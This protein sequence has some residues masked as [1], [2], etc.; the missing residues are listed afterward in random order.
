MGLPRLA[1]KRQCIFHF[2][3]WNILSLSLQP[4]CKQSVL[5][6]SSS[7]QTSWIRPELHEEREG[8]SISPQLLQSPPD[9]ICQRNPKLDLPSRPPEFLTS[10]T[11]QGSKRIAGFCSFV[12]L[13]LRAFI[14]YLGIYLG[15]E[16]YRILTSWPGIQP[17][18][19]NTLQQW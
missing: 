1:H 18:P 11:M 7:R 19:G 10:E 8:Y 3:W 2:I 14:F 4:L 6:G 13:L 5:W 17:M 12:F 15:C 16:A 9:L